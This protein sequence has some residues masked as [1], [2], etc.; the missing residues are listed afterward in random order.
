MR[1]AIKQAELAKEK[2]EVPAG[3][4]I[5]R[6][7]QQADT[8]VLTVIGRAHNQVEMLHDPTAHAEMIAITQAAS[9]V[10]DWRL[11]DTILYV[12]KE[13]CAMCSGAIVLARIPLV[14]YGVPDPLRG[15]AAS[16]FKILN[17]PAMN[18]R[19]DI[20][21]GILEEECRALLQ[22]FF[23]EKRSPKFPGKDS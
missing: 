9:A 21:S 23:R 4:V 1:L 12:T 2:N 20:I 17:H 3:C 18:H 10:G 22:D 15:G 14:V 5:I 6:T 13:P 11:T 8:P 19:S 7:T 16:V